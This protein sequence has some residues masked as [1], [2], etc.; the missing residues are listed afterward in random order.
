MSV[1]KQLYW[2][3]VVDTELAER[4]QRLAEV[5]AS[6]AES[7]DLIRARGAVAETEESLEEL[8][9]QMRTLDLDISAVSAKL[10]ANQERLYGGRVKNPKELNNLQE[11]ATA[12]R[13]RLSELEDAQLELL[14][15]IEE[16]EAELAERQARLR[17]I[18]ASWREEQSGLAAEKEQLE[19]RLA[20]LEEQRSG[21]RSTI[22]AA[23]LA[24]YD[25]LCEQMGGT[26]VVLLRR[27]SCQV[28]GVAVPTGVARA[29]ER[30]EGLHFCPVCGRLL[31]A[32]A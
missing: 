25:D 4:R 12:L 5:E 30:G 32:G 29:V 19:Q 21:Q 10:K 16:G 27:G 14:I 1:A 13:R 24:L 15:G 2:L 3:Q 8:Q 11:E 23:D 31:Y 18:E 20:E 9:K 26:G 6:L 17:Q 28:C 7:G 22:A